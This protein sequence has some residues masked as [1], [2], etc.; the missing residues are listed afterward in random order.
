MERINPGPIGCLTT[1]DC[2]R[3]VHP[4]SVCLNLAAAAA[5][6]ATTGG[7]SSPSSSPPLTSVCSNPYTSGCFHTLL[8]DGDDDGTD[9]TS[10]SSSSANRRYLPRVCHSQDTQET[11]DAG[12]CRPKRSETT[13]LP[14]YPEV[15]LYSNNWESSYLDTWILQALLSE[16]M[17][18][19]TTIEIGHDVPNDGISRIVNHSPLDLYSPT[20]SYYPGSALSEV[21]RGWESLYR[22]S[23]IGDCRR[24]HDNNNNNNNN[25]VDEQTTQNGSNDEYTPCAHVITEIWEPEQAWRMAIGTR[26]GSD[27]DENDD[28]DGN[29]MPTS[30]VVSRGGYVEPPQGLGVLAQEGWY[31][32]QFTARHDPS[33]TSYWGLVGQR[34]KLASLFLRPTTWGQYCREESPSNC[35]VADGVAKRP[36]LTKEESDRYF[37]QQN[38]STSDSLINNTATT[39][40][41]NSTDGDGVIFTGY[42]RST[43]DNNCEVWPDNCTGHIVDY[44]CD[45][46]SQAA[47]QAYH[48]DIPVKGNGKE[49]KVNG[50]KDVEMREIW[51]AANYTKSHV[52]MYYWE[53]DSLVDRYVDSEAEFT[54]IASPTPTQECVE[55]R[56]SVAGNSDLRCNGETLEE[57]VGDPLG[58]CDDPPTPLQKVMSKGLHQMIYDTSIPDALRSPAYEVI[59]LFSIS[60]L[61]LDEVFSYW[62]RYGD[63]R[64]AVCHWLVD[65]EDWA[66]QFIP[67]SYPRAVH[68]ETTS[69][70]TSTLSIFTLVLASMTVFLVL[71]TSVLVYIKRDSRVLKYAQIEFISLILTG[72]FTT[73]IGAILVAIP[74]SDGVCVATI[75]MLLLGSTI[76]LLPLLV[77]ISAVNRLFQAASAHR[78]VTLKRNR[79]FGVVF[80]ITLLVCIFLA[81]WT[82]LDPPSQQ[83]E[84]KLTGNQGES[85]RTIITSTAYCSSDSDIWLF[86]AVGWNGVMVLAATVLAFQSRKI[87][88]QDFNE[89]AV[90]GLIAWQKGILL[91]LQVLVRT[92][93]EGK[94]D[95]DVL[96]WCLSIIY[97]IDTIITLAIYFVPKVLPESGKSR[98]AMWAK[99]SIRGLSQPVGGEHGNVVYSPGPRAALS[100]PPNVA[101]SGN[102]ITTHASNDS[103][104]TIT[105]PSDNKNQSKTSSRTTTCSGC[106]HRWLPSCCPQCGRSV[107]CALDAIATTITTVTTSNITA[108]PTALA[109]GETAPLTSAMSTS[110]AEKEEDDKKNCDKYVD[111]DDMGSNHVRHD[112]DDEKDNV[113]HIA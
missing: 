84:Y 82:G 66:R 89:S 107:P 64:D 100:D 90:L 57:R 63:P 52:I 11:I 34:E 5:A 80:G 21:Y 44:P 113:V 40:N 108:T 56:V 38:G 61:Q 8:G 104:P 81:L 75:L 109:V 29:Y 111:T 39:M 94:V 47:Q 105:D 55:H 35:T 92:F 36:P 59:Q 69:V 27:G 9:R 43:D 23:E 106:G 16:L 53:P 4:S 74:A 28:D 3:Q 12:L 6:A 83:Q 99:R 50:Y 49:G 67:S 20:R 7:P 41:L 1:A 86:L 32:P 93:L 102:C 96:A 42:F 91:I 13:T 10:S 101:D 19:P 112:D 46:T 76:Q 110:S 48:L 88:L 72:L 17:E 60:T 26:T 14:G 30:R 71:G 45:W 98:L 73:A 54:K 25:P 37:Y 77:K 58:S 22:S 87:K 15:R 24:F 68:T 2:V 78:R 85:G 95:H 62:R 18:V 65:N 103:T 33:L 97:S 70:T 79:L 31:I 51:M